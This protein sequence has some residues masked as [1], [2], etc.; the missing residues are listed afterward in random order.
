MNE[1]KSYKMPYFAMVWLM[2]TSTDRKYGYIK[3]SEQ[4]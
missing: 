3:K 2:L 1:D 4:Y